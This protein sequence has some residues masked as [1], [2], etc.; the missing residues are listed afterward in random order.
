[1]VA[2]AAVPISPRLSACTSFV[3]GAPQSCALFLDMDGT[4]L[5]LAETPETVQIPDGLVALL[6]RLEQSLDGAVAIISGRVIRDIDALLYPANLA[7]S[8]VH[9]AELRKGPGESIESV[10]AQLPED[11]LDSMRRLAADMPGVLIEP[12][13][14][15]LAIHYRRMPSAEPLVLAA[16]ERALMQHAGTFEILRGKKLFEIVPSGLSKGTALARLC[17]LPAF[18][19]RVPIMIG[20]DIGDE[21]A[22]SVAESMKGFALRVAGEHYGDD[23]ADFAGPRAVVRWL[24]QLSHR[25]SVI[26]ASASRG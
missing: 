15:G 4:L 2:K 26:E 12:K 22:F 19:D 23:I 14:P 24:E 1:M 18:E 9:G 3:L 5:E 10:K 8:G 20:D 7:A 13:P 17:K 21:A 11:L 25:L 16:L 6:Q